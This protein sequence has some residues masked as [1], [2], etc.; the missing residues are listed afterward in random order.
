MKR[1]GEE[2]ALRVS[3][4]DQLVEDTGVEISVK[5]PQTTLHDAKKGCF[6]DGYTRHWSSLSLRERRTAEEAAIENWDEPELMEF[7]RK[8]RE[9]AG[10]KKHLM[11][12]WCSV[13]SPSSVKTG[14]VIGI[15]VV[16]LFFFD[17]ADADEVELRLQEFLFQTQDYSRYVVKVANAICLTDPSPLLA[18]QAL[19]LA[20]IPHVLVRGFSKRIAKQ[21][22]CVCEAL[23][24]SYERHCG[25]E[26][27][28]PVGS[29][30]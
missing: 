30:L 29:G 26:N 20:V 2:L 27:L 11:R 12:E 9:L 17:A 22:A 21:L 16:E 8:L 25:C 1:T 14:V 4:V 28:H 19:R 7:G 10:L 24:R 18:V 13:A 5:R 23:Q 6:V 3:V 15:V